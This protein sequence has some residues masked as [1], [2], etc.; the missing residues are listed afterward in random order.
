MAG[1]Q[2]VEIFG[3]RFA[4]KPRSILRW[5]SLDFLP[6]W[7]TSR[8]E[9]LLTVT[10]TGPPSQQATLSWFIKFPGGHQTGHQ[11]TVPALQTGET[12]TL[13]V[14]HRL[15]GF[16]GDT[17]LVIPTSDLACSSAAQYH[18]LYAFHTTPK[19]WIFLTLA[20]A[21]LSAGLS[22]LGHWLF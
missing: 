9:F 6:Y 2:S 3:Y 13:R 19:T 21:V 22:T 10:R 11:E 16:T 15:L 8:P 12:H 14:G 18:A 17:L 5:L 4:A 1:G 7:Q 20:V